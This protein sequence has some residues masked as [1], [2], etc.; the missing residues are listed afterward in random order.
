MD[1]KTELTPT[2]TPSNFRKQ[3]SKLFKQVAKENL[4]IRVTLP[5]K[6]EGPNQDIFVIGAQDYAEYLKLK[7][8]YMKKID[9][10]ISE[11]ASAIP[12][13]KTS[14]PKEVEAWLNGD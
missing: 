2:Y 4:T 7:G 10:E 3:Q 12:H 1:L 5:N 13:K 11:M 8:D 9:H 14:D 6:E